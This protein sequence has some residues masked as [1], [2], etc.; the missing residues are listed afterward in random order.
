MVSLVKAVQVGNVKLVK[1]VLA[2][3]A[4][5]HVKDDYALGYAAHNGHTEVVKLFKR[6]K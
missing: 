2:A 3:G 1:A 6:S 4:D 5:I